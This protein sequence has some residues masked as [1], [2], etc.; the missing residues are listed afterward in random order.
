MAD[1]C[2][3]VDNMG[4]LLVSLGHDALAKPLLEL[5]GHRFKNRVADAQRRAEAALD[6]TVPMVVEGDIA[7]D[8]PLVGGYVGRAGRLS[9]TQ[10]DA[11]ELATLNKLGLRP[12]FVGIE[13]DA[14]KQAIEG[15]VRRAPP[16]LDDDGTL[17]LREGED[18]AGSWVLP[19]DDDAR[20]VLPLDGGR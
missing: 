10:L 3:A 5:T 1:F 14:I 12:T 13:R 2:S 4:S 15:T 18:G 6:D 20:R 16:A 8:T 19:L 11:S 9:A 7:P 17:S